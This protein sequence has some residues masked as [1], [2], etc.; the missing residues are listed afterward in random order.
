MGSTVLGHTEPVRGQN[1]AGRDS[2]VQES[3]EKAQRETAL[4]DSSGH[5]ATAGI[6]KVDTSRAMAKAV[7][8]EPLLEL[9]KLVG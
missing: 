7:G 1:C 9:M 8:E 5:R 6:A 4:D 2:A 3:A